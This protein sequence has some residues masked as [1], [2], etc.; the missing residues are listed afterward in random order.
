MYPYIQLE[1]NLLISIIKQYFWKAQGHNQ[2]PGCRVACMSYD[3]S[4][5]LSYNIWA[6]I[7]SKIIVWFSPV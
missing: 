3:C 2:I 7:H 1:Y 4:L 5:G 6:R